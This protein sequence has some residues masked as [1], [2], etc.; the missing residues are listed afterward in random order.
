MTPKQKQFL[1]SLDKRI[2]YWQE[3]YMANHTNEIDWAFRD[4]L[5]EVR[6]IRNDFKKLF[7]EEE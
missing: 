7:G 1:A 4:M 5:I 2:K 3:K 6:A